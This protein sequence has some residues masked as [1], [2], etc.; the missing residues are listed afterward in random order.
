MQYQFSNQ[1]T[2]ISLPED[3][4]DYVE[5]ETAKLD[6]IM[7]KFPEDSMLRVIVSDAEGVEDVEILLRLS[8]PNK[9]LNSRETGS[10]KHIQ[11]VLSRA[12]KELRRQVLAYKDQM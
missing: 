1:A 11:S 10:A 8:L 7:A 5:A 12:L 3:F 2:H 6:P 4:G 9:L